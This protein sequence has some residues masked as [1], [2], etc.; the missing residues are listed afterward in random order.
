MMSDEASEFACNA[1]GKVIVNPVT[2]WSVASVDAMAVLCRVEYLAHEVEPAAAEHS[3]VQLLLTPEQAIEL[4]DVLVAQANRVLD[5][6][7]AAPV[8]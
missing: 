4:A 8:V 3:N 1:N 6:A 5:Q 2:G 7:T